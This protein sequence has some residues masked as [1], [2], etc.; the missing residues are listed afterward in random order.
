MRSA[1]QVLL[2]VGTSLLILKVVINVAFNVYTKHSRKM[3]SAAE[4]NEEILDMK[5]Y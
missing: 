4:E 2:Y 1:Y 5:N 3:E